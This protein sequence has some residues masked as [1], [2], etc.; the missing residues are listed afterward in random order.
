MVTSLVMQGLISP[1]KECRL[2]PEVCRQPLEGF[3]KRRD[4]IDR[5]MD[6]GDVVYIHSGI[7][8]SHKKRMK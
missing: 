4:F 5:G 8:L 6:K 3:Q 7:L 1:G 2:V